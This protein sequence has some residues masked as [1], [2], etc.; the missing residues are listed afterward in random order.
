MAKKIVTLYI[1][2][3]SIRL[4]ITRGKRIKEWADM[5]LP[6]GLIRN[7][8]V[9]E[10]AEV[11][12]KIKQLFQDRKVKAKICLGLSGLHCLSRPITLPQL[13]P[14]MLTEAV[15][16]EARRVL[17]VPLEQLYL[18]WQ[19]IPSP[20]G[21]T[22]VFLVAIPCKTIDALLKVLR[23]VGLKP[24]LMDVKPLLLSRVVKETTA[25]VVDVQPT[26][27]DI[28][29]MVDG[30]PHP[31]RTVSLPREAVSWQQTLS[32]IKDEIDR[33]IKFYNSNNPERPLLS[34][35]PI[36]ASGAMA[37]EP[38][39]RQSLSDELGHPVVLLSAPLKK[40]PE[41]LDP[42]RY[43]VNI[44]LVLK[45]LSS[46]RE[47]GIPVVNLNA[48]PVPYQ[49]KPF[50][51]T[52]VLVLPGAAVTVSLLVFLIVFIQS[53]AAGIALTRDQLASTSQHLKQNL[54]QRQELM[55]K[56]TQ[57]EAFRGNFTLALDSLAEQSNV[58]NGNLE[59]ALNSLPNNM[60]LS[61][62]SY[63]K[64]TLTIKGK[65]PT[66]EGIYLYLNNLDSSGRFCEIT[67]T[68]LKRI[69]DQEM[70]FSLILR[71]KG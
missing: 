4:L 68:N 51:L 43:L 15:K 54:D 58:V 71:T 38:G 19:T 50:S 18:T 62:I 9:I 1:D 7:G 57:A 69:E 55:Q 31:V 32:T 33:T 67:I 60:R 61:S 5:P 20:E 65:S 56:A 16:R 42:R 48:L 70:E 17:P 21:K 24:D 34:S 49:P 23:Q 37:D 53:T 8:V 41:G 63:D 26:E 11:T 29:I 44:G 64:S 14:V 66:E 27:F 28:V 22:R 40:Y 3:A 30:V 13:P 59:A 2:D 10:E 6:P 36:F 39:L 47:A 52:R 35:V 46:G 25:I 45:K 12:T